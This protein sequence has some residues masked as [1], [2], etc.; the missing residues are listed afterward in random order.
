MGKFV[1]S[2]NNRVEVYQAFLE[3]LNT[4]STEA[5]NH[6]VETGE[7]YNDGGFVYVLKGQLDG[8]KSEF[9]SQ[10]EQL[11]YRTNELIKTEKS[12]YFEQEK[13]KTVD[14]EMQVSN[15]LKFIE[16]EGSSINDEK[17]FLILKDFMD[18]HEKMH[19]FKNVIEKQLDP[20]NKDQIIN[21]KKT[22]AKFNE[23]EALLNTFEELESTAKDIFIRPLTKKNSSILRGQEFISEYIPAYWDLSGFS[24]LI[25]L[26]EIVE[27]L[28]PEDN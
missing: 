20:M 13:V 3:K 16:I 18:D 14:Y 11:N 5:I 9:Q 2:L 8:L 7:I 26:A 28:I 19:L 17:A 4:D 12:K 10:A 25:N 1:E 15:A 22:F 24:E 21:F 27:N 6:M 23:K